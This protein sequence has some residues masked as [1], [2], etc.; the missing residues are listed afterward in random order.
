M[1]YDI[2]SITAKM[3]ED[4]VAE[5]TRRGDE[6]GQEVVIIDGMDKA[7]VGTCINEYGKI[8]AVYDRE[9][10]IQCLMESMSESD[11]PEDDPY[12]S[13]MEFFEYN[14]VRSLPYLKDQAPIIIELL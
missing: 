12:E 11:D 8:V 4:K 14:T 3:A 6:R 5:V 7:I 10:C 2:Y 9:L 13:A 1:E